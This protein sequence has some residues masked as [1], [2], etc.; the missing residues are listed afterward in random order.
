MTTFTPPTLATTT[1]TT[2]TTHSLILPAS[3]HAYVTNNNNK[4]NKNP[5]IIGNIA[6]MANADML[7]I[8]YLDSLELK[9]D[10]VDDNEQNLLIK[11]LEDK[12]A[13]KRT[14]VNLLCWRTPPNIPLISKLLTLGCDPNSTDIDKWC[15]LHGA[16]C[17]GELQLMEILLH[18]GADP[19][20][21]NRDGWTALHYIIQTNHAQA[22]DFIHTLV[23]AGANVN[24][25]SNSGLTP[26]EMA[27]SS[28]KIALVH[29]LTDMVAPIKSSKFLA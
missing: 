11:H 27:K 10:E 24:I 9:K 13:S 14:A 7:T 15:A 23:N 8:E 21:Q 22:G 20:Q 18:H 28:N 6:I 12:T 5:T 17:N 1:P 19:N 26:L 2:P 16:A 3:I 29:I 4:I 25:A